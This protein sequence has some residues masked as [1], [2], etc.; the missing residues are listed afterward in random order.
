ML[1]AL[2][3]GVGTRLVLGI[4]ILEAKRIQGGRH[5]RRQALHWEWEGLFTAAEKRT[6][7]LAIDHPRGRIPAADFQNLRQ[8]VLDV[9]RINYFFGMAAAPASSIPTMR[10]RMAAIPAVAP[11]SLRAELGHI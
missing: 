5:P 3:A 4:E 6:I 11:R 9:P 7:D 8:G 10:L 2:S 1:F